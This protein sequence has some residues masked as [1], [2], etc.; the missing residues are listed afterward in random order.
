MPA[1]TPA[2]RSRVV[3]PKDGL[4]YVSGG[5]NAASGSEAIVGF[6]VAERVRGFSSVAARVHV[7]VLAV[8]EPVF[9]PSR[10]TGTSW[11]R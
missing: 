10:T 1:V 9:L 11:R 7:T 6:A 2:P 3:I 8:L 5:T 4:E